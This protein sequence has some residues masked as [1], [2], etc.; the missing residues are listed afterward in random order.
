MLN[1][2]LLVIEIALISFI[3]LEK[4]F[5]KSLAALVLISFAST[6]FLIVNSANMISVATHFI[7]TAVMMPAMGYWLI[8]STEKKSKLFHTKKNIAAIILSV[9]VLVVVV[10]QSIG[11]LPDQILSILFACLSFLLLV[12]E[13]NFVKIFIALIAIENAFIMLVPKFFNFFANNTFVEIWFSLGLILPLFVLASISIK[14]YKK[15][16]SI[17]VD[18]NV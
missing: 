14:M 10:F 1:F 5:I 13:K 7:S 9:S 12:I 17:K 3:Y 15:T 8:S 6:L 18:E 16:G 11:F 2:A 4:D